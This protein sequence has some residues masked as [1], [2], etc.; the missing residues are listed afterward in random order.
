L[1]KK[2]A[3]HAAQHFRQHLRRFPVNRLSADNRDSLGDFQQGFLAAR[4]GNQD[5]L[6]GFALMILPGFFSG[7]AVAR[8][9]G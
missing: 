4:G 6:Q 8:S 2:R 9:D 7:P 5:R 1:L 3:G